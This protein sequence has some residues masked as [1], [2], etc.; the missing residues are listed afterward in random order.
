MRLLLKK[1]KQQEL[2]KKEKEM[3]GLTWKE[4][5]N[6][7]GLKFGKLLSYYNEECLI[8]SSL[9]NNLHFSDNFR[10]FII[11]EKSDNW[12]RKKGGTISKG[13]TKIIRLPEDSEDLAEL[14]GI[15]LGDGNS[16]KI[17]DYKIGTYMIRIVGH[18]ELDKEYLLDY[19]KPI[20]ERLFSI[21]VK[22]GYAKKSNAI[23]IQ[24]HGVELINFFESK[25]FKPGNKIDNQLRIPSWIFE[26]N[27]YLSVCLRGLFDTD[28]SIYKLTNQNTH[29]INFKNYNLKLLEDVRNGLLSLGINCSNI[30]KGNSVYITKK[31][32]LAKFFKSI[33][34]RNP[35]HLNRLKMFG[36]AP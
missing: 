5:A 14:Y 33:G 12:G 15:M 11:E 36:I 34:F 30:S 23:F 25:G 13:S 35:K 28:G 6:R 7:L 3:L 32:E 29:Q 24:A 2:L 17:K 20:I 26:N 4:L 22:F 19:V 1:G 27:N 10:E 8:D 16:T 21:K 18:A 31:T 9:F